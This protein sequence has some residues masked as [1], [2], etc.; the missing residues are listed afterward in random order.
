MTERVTIKGIQEAQRAN[1]RAIA[2]LQPQGR[3]GRAL[4]MVMAELHRYAVSIT[5]VWI[6]WGGAL[7]ASHRI[8]VLTLTEN[9]GRGEIFIDP[10]AMNPRGQRPSVYGIYE[11]ARGGE[12]A[13]YE[14]TVNQAGPGAV[15]RAMRFLQEGLG[16]DN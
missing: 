12:H 8:G 16:R 3:L 13:F 5:H 4:Q 2:T 9:N 10:S 6:V 15:G 7:R 11:H 1:L 14:R